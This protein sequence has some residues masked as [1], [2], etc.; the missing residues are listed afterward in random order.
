MKKNELTTNRDQELAQ[1]YMGM[2][3]GNDSTMRSSFM[4]KL[5]DPRRDIDAE[6][7]YPSS[8]GID[9]YYALYSRE[10]IATRV[11]NIYPEES[12][13]DDFSVSDD[14]E[15][16]Y[17]PD[18][19]DTE[20]EKAWKQL[21]E[22]NQI[23]HYLQRIDELSGLGSFGVLFMGFDD[24]L[25]FSKPMAGINEK[26]ELDENTA[27]ENTK[28]LYL[29]PFDQRLVTIHSFQMDIHNPR[30]GLPVMYTLKFMNPSTL[31]QR[32]EATNTV[33][34]QVHWSRILHVADNRK[35]SEIYGQPRMETVFN[36]LY[37]IRKVLGGSGD[38]FWKGA[39]PGYSF[40]VNPQMA[41]IDG[42]VELDV[43]S[44]RQ[45]FE[46]YSNGLQRYLALSG[47]SAKSLSP[48]V[49][50][51]SAHIDTEAK[52][53]AV[54]LGIPYRIFIGSEEAKLASSED[55]KR[56]NKRLKKRQEKYLTP[57][58]VRPFVDRM[59]MAG[60]LPKP[61]DNIYQVE[62]PDLNEM[63][64]KQKADVLESTSRAYI[65]LINA[66]NQGAPLGLKDL[67]DIAL[68]FNLSNQAF[69]V[70]QTEL[71]EQGNEGAL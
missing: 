44:M 29:R 43:E 36:R 54:C 26:G 62:W 56:W 53:V 42:G 24:G 69:A 34:K 12:W 60:V 14:L 71:V 10:G 17:M 47:V 11:V 21:N 59:I 48:Q 61:K 39:F 38:M 5:L 9:Q 40:E 67:H 28:L 3:V 8:L 22:K 4:N 55:T 18:Q 33:D 35:S 57:M 63:T 23:C 15:L 19:K 32:E 30:Y 41:G 16:P 64:P 45:E 58:M 13:V 25:D 27:R 52:M 66:R 20:F 2:L 46:R 31:D 1:L 50:D 6:C 37:D 65:Q 49:A 68:E 51:P 7:G 70:V